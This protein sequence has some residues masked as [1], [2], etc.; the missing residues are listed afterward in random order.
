MLSKQLNALS[1]P[2][3][4]WADEVRELN[5]QLIECLEQLSEREKELSDHEE[6]LR[7]YEG[8]LGSMRQQTA[9][10]YKD[11]MESTEKT[12]S[13]EKRLNRQIDEVRS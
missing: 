7:R 11:H 9:L 10:L 5:A 13:T 12:A 3:E 4:E 2:P 6:L 8:H 1:L